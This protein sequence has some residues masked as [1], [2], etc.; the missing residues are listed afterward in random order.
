M[1]FRSQVPTVDIIIEVGKQIVL[2][3][4][5]NPPHGWVLPDGFIDYRK[6]LESA[7]RREDLEET[8]LVVNLLGQFHAY[9][10]PSRDL[11]QHNIS[12]VFLAKS[13]ESPQ[14]GADALGAK[15]FKENA[16]PKNLV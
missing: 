16:L 13:K 12:T 2:I 8:G 6:T 7:A 10:D 15:C 11:R 14:A 9:S 5:M 1:S 4:R 3:E